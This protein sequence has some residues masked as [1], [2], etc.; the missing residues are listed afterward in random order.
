MSN[1][2]ISL[3]FGAGA[4]GWVY[5][6]MMHKTGNNTQS[7]VIVGVIAGALAFMVLM[8]LLNTLEGWMN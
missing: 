4:A 3:I 7:A 5:S 6:K 1:A 8:V 2:V